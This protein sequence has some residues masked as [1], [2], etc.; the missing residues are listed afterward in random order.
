MG[1]LSALFKSWLPWAVFGAAGGALYVGQPWIAVIIVGAGVIGAL[2]ATI[3]RTRRS[4]ELDPTQ[5]LSLDS[6]ARMRPLIRAQKQLADITERNGAHPAIKVIGSEAVKEADEIVAKAADLLKARSDLLHAGLSNDSARIDNLKAKLELATDLME[7]ER[8]EAALALAEGAADHNAQRANALA[9][10]DA[11]LDE[12]REA[13]EATRAELAAAL[14]DDG[15][16]Q[17]DLREHLSQLQSLG[18]SL[19]EAKELLRDSS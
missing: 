12:A 19:D 6:Q 11:Q 5:G 16:A 4:Y 14:T 13:L 3:G 10:I 7:R 1:P 2:A 8:L 18:E 15:T 9:Q 17:E